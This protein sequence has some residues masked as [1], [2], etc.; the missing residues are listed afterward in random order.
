MT[1][2]QLTPLLKTTCRNGIEIYQQVF[3]A[4]LSLADGAP[5]SESWLSSLRTMAQ[6]SAL[7]LA[8]TLRTMSEEEQ[9]SAVY[10]SPPPALR[11]ALIEIALSFTLIASSSNAE[12]L[13]VQPLYQAAELEPLLESESV[14]L[15]LGY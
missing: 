13:A 7:T 11:T 15:W 3:P 1:A 9:E 10:D 8:E 6:A 5:V 2:D 4:L 12:Q 14:R